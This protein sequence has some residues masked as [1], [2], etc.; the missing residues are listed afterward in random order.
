MKGIPSSRPLWSRVRK[1][2]SLL[3][4]STHSPTEILPD[5]VALIP[6]PSTPTALTRPTFCTTVNER[7]YVTASGCEI[8][9]GGTERRQR[10]VSTAVRFV[11]LQQLIRPWRHSRL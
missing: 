8:E 11:P 5:L 9:L 7:V 1:I 6:F 10:S 4:I 3:R 2:S